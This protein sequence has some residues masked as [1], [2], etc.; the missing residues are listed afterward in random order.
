MKILIAVDD[1]AYSQAA[2][3]WAKRMDWPARTEFLVLSAA[4]PVLAAYALAGAAPAP[5]SGE[6]Y[7]A[8]MKQHEEIAARFEGQLRDHGLKS[9][10]LVRQGD[11]RDAIVE[12]AREH[13]ADLIVVGSHGRAGISKLV[14][15]S[16]ANHVVTHAPCSV[17]VVKLAPRAAQPARKPVRS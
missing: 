13:G 17:L 12:T 9:R 14:L 3:D 7:E 8:D 2:M 1:S 10:A 11:P 6:L 15:G 4:Q 16:V 5:D